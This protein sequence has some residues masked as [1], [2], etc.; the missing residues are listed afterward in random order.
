MCECLS[1]LTLLL[2][3]F[4]Q[5]TAPAWVGVSARLTIVSGASV[6]QVLNIQI[7]FTHNFTCHPLCC[8]DNVCI[9]AVLVR[10]VRCLRAPRRAASPLCTSTAADHSQGASAQV[11]W[12]WVAGVEECSSLVSQPV[13]STTQ[14]CAGSLFHS[15]GSYTAPYPRLWANGESVCCNDWPWHS[16]L[17]LHVPAQ[18]ASHST[19]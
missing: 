2:P 15:Q 9:H 7:D 3:S 10:M 18:A 19:I 14:L 4:A 13:P 6:A 8:C 1:G 5:Q 17:Q 11:R 16:C 12:L